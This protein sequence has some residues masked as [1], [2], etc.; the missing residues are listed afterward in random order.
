MLPGV[1]PVVGRTDKEAREKLAVLQGFLDS[2][3][4]LQLLT[5]RLGFDMT[6]YDFDGP[7]PELPQT[8]FSQTFARVLLAKARADGMTLRDLYNLNAAARGHW[9]LCGSP[10]TIADTLQHW[11]E[12]RAGDGFNV[13]PPWFHDGFDDFVD[14]VVPI[15][16]ERGLFRRDYEGT[17]LRD[18]LGLER[19]R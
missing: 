4:G 15:L 18:L 17:T 16:Q 12:E 1:M 19:P 11:F 13:M 5:D 14:G 3:N 8:E 6:K 2:T 9:V 7:V 10:V